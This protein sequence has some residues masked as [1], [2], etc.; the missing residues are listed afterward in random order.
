MDVTTH[1]FGA[2]IALRP[3]QID[4]AKIDRFVGRMHR[5]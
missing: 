2:N 5:N 1:T 3:D 4:L